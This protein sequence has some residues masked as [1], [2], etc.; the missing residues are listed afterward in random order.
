MPIANEPFPGGE[1]QLS[2]T[3]MNEAEIE[4]FRHKLLDLKAELQDL[5]ESSET[6]TSAEP[7]QT[8]LAGLSRKDAMQ[9]HL[10]AQEPARRRHRQLGKIEGAFRRIEAGDYG[11]CFICGEEIDIHRLSADPTNTRCMKCV[12]AS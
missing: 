11:N 1:P 8:A 4:Q 6:A 7:G 9:A 5:E 12:E 2:E 10:M 3:E